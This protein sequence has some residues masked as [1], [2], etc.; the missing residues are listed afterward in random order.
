M[1]AETENERGRPAIGNGGHS[2]PARAGQ[3]E[4]HLRQRRLSLF[5]A[6]LPCG[7]W[8]DPI[9]HVAIDSF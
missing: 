9:V 6:S 5:A 7:G 3:A 4:E 1:S 8:M 2:R